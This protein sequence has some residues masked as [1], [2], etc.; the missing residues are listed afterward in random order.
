[1]YLYF[2]SKLLVLKGI[3]F[4][5]A[6][7]ISELYVA[8]VAGQADEVRNRRRHE[9]KNLDKKQVRRIHNF[10]LKAGA[11]LATL[12]FEPL[13]DFKIWGSSRFRALENLLKN[14]K[15]LVFLS[16]VQFVHPTQHVLRSV[17]LRQNPWC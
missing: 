9:R 14:E 10:P 12:K 17:I 4:Q 15:L 5:R 11:S 3:C 1:M 8:A 6:S 16:C 2:V 13:L 7:L